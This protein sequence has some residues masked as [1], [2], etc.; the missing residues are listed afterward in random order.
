MPLNKPIP[1]V[2]RPEGAT[3]ASPGHR[4][5]NIVREPS[6]ALKGRSNVGMGCAFS[7]GIQPSG[8]LGT[9]TQ[10]VA[11]GLLGS[12]RCPLREGSGL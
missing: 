9:D 12:G 8:I 6:L 10:G 4:P 1:Y 2:F 5:G 3:Y 11:L 7:P